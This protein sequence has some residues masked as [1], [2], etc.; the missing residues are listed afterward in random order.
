MIFLGIES[1][2]HT[3][4]IGVYDSKKKKILSNA[5]DRYPSGK[6]GFIPRK[7]AEHHEKSYAR[8]LKD[9][10][11]QS[12]VSLNEIDAIGYSHGPGI[13]HCLH[14]GWIAAKSLSELTGKPIVPVNHCV[15][16][17]EVTKFFTHARD[18]LVLYVSGGNTQIIARDG[19]RY[20]VFGETIDIGVGNFLD[21]LGRMLKLESPDAVGVMNEAKGGE[22]IDLPYS[23]KGM[24]V[25]F[26]GLLTHCEKLFQQKLAS[27][28]DLC[29][30]AQETA[31]AMVIEASERALKHLGKKEVIV[32]GGVAC[33]TRLQEMLSIMASENKCSFGVAAN[34]YNRDNG[35]MIALTASKFFENNCVS[36]ETGINQRQRTDAARICW[37]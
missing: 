14:V 30:S 35:G 12:G 11:K 32:C 24:N 16:H 34:E 4:G 25:S 33:N 2:A 3:L 36:M 18:P 15:A 29:Y 13:G 7:L 17:I 31:F 27:K 28:K 23:V 5:L 22:M 9:C 1:T 20:K 26:T 6:K 19:E 21:N 8:V 10:L 37:K